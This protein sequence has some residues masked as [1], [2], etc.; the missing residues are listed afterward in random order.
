[1][2]KLFFNF[3]V[4]LFSLSLIF[5][6]SL[7]IAESDEIFDVQ[8]IGNNRVD[9]STVITYSGIRSGDV[10]LESNVE[11]ALKKLY[12]TE[13]FSDVVIKYS[14][15]ILTIEIT[16][17]ALINQVAFEGNKSIDDQALQAVSLLK[18]RATYSNKKLEQDIT[19]IINAYRS[20]GRY[21]VFVEPKII[22]L[23]YNRINLV[24]EINEGSATEI[25]DINFIGN[26]NY[27]DRKLRNVIATT[28]ST[29]ID[30]IWGTGKSYDNQLMEYDKELLKEYYRNK[31]YVN[32]KVLNAVAELNSQNDQFLI[33]FTVSEGERYNFGQINITDQT[34]TKASF[35][36][37]DIML[38]VRGDVYSQSNIEKSSLAI[39][40][41]LRKN[42]NPFAQVKVLE[43]IN[44][45]DKT[46][47]IN[48]VIS[49]GPQLYIERIDINGN[50]RTFDYVIRRRL[51]ISEGD[52][53]NSTYLNNSIRNIRTLNFFSDVQ[54]NTV[55]GS[56]PDR[57]IIKIT[58]NEK[59][60]GSLIFG[61]GYSS[62]SGVLGTIS[63]AEKNLL[64]KGQNMTLDLNIGGNQSLVNL[65]FTEPA[66]LDTPVSAGFDI[67]GNQS[68]YS[69]QSGYKNKQV[70]A[71]VRFGFPLS[72]ELR[73]NVK[74]SY[75]NN[76]VFSVPSTAALSLRQLEGEKS[77]SEV[78]YNLIYNNLDNFFTPSSGFLIDFSQD[79]AGLGGDIKY[80]RS[81]I[82]GDYYI[83]FTK[84]IIGS[85]SLGAGHI[86]G[87]DDQDVRISDAFMDPG[88]ILRGFQSRGIS[89]RLKPD[90]NSTAALSGSNEEAI[91]G[92]T[93]I[94]TSAGIK[95]PI[96]SITEDYGIKGGLHINAGTL[97]D[98]DL[99]DAIVNESNSIRT[100][101]G[102]S[103]FWDSPIGPLR[104]DFTEAINKETY[105]RTEFFQFSGGTSF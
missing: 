21:S 70:G 86:F 9:D 33:T 24:F 35:P 68:D 4:L 31:G 92:N 85:I 94:S 98:S 18:P 3:F 59:P 51:T 32:F 77:I 53:L 83:D 104:F 12:A 54:V 38:T 52:A 69:E 62:V 47:D 36:I 37:N 14:N 60:T 81:E 58:V 48:Y 42:G 45:T 16:E 63:V 97:Y 88:L 43:Q 90:D 22:K 100:S 74:Y 13:L 46:I 84:D 103:I 25:I 91:G 49:D 72:D 99:D 80:I 1:M 27:S 66:F 56:A 102:A 20:A 105:D 65:S 40:D 39:V 5:D 75:T 10:Y 73:F 41:Y 17:N 29:F 78:G 93:F 61:A 67:Y 87:L 15:S 26:I 76:E 6:S 19:N 7:S 89:P 11:E 95:F 82:S 101:V 8:V 55:Q 57:R 23:D 30:K 34:S 50:Q 96:P 44:V 64:G 2:K 71:G 79:I 28:R